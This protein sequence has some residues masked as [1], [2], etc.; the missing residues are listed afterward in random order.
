MQ[1][2]TYP[3]ARVWRQLQKSVR[4]ASD[5][6]VVVSS[7]LF[8]DATDAQIPAIIDGLG[9]DRV[10][11]LV[12]V[13][14]LEKLLPSTWQQAI[15][16]GA[17]PTYENWINRVLRGPDGANLSKTARK[18]WSRHDHARLVER[19]A[20]VVGIDNVAVL[21][22]DESNPANLLHDVEQLIGVP[23][24]SLRP[25][26]SRNR[27]PHRARGRSRAARLPGPGR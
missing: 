22:V 27:S 9:A 10:R 24:G 18:F 25:G 1:H 23:R 3:K 5:R 6:K 15:K 4:R 12:T 14:P 16:N 17:P 26:V 21:V 20:A 2:G 7:E 11:V 13:R 8:S 19:W